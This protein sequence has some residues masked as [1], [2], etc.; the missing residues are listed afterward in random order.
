MTVF[1]GEEEG[2]PGTC[3]H[4]EGHVKTQH[5]GGHLQVKERL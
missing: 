1:L 3:A 4:R 2:T 5:G